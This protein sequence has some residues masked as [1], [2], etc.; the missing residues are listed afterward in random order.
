[1]TNDVNKLSSLEIYEGNAM[2]FVGDGNALPI[3]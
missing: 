1:M 2:I 3:S